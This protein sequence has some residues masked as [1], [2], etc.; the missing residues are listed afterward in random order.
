MPL[1]FTLGGNVSEIQLSSIRVEDRLREDL[2]ELGELMAS[3]QQYGLLHPIVIDDK[4]RLIA[5]HRRLEASRRL[6]KKRIE[7]K[8][9]GELSAEERREIELEENIQRK[10]LT[11]YERSKKTM[12]LAEVAQEIAA[13][14]VLGSAPKKGRPTKGKA[15]QAAAAERIG[16][17]QKT[18]SRAEEHVAAA[19]RY[20][21]LQQPGWS[22]D[23][24]LVTAKKLDA[25]AAQDRRRICS[26][27]TSSEAP[28]KEASTMISGFAELDSEK[29]SKLWEL[30]KSHDER[31][32]SAVRTYLADRAPEA[33]PRVGY[34]R[35]V[36]GELRR[37]GKRFRDD[38]FN[39]PLLRLA[40]DAEQ[41]ANRIQ[42][43]QKHRVKEVVK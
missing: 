12:E 31:D 27:V 18:V 2:G 16:V 35:S 3:I 22:Q 32:R 17:D 36:T 41:L 37:Q 4:R 9:L 33:D 19:E 24:A 28:P 34:L 6:G 25:L 42:E 43:A 21:F 11:E 5:G 20:P 13:K 14:E 40:E 26:I 15:S 30:S 38:A 23:R 8:L 39:G 7:V 29:R 1:P 10:D